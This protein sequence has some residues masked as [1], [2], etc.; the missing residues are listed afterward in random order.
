M[1]AMLAQQDPAMAGAAPPPMDP[2]MMGAPPPEMAPRMA[3]EMG[4]EGMPAE[5]EP[6]DP[7]AQ[8]PSL[9][10][11][12]MAM[13]VEQMVSQLQQGEH[14]LLEQYQQAARAMVAQVLAEQMAGAGPATL[15]GQAAMTPGL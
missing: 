2:A 8:F 4:P 13:L 3:P 10:P 14:Q 9:D 6:A 7:A 15:D 11:G 1:A 5:G 12:Q